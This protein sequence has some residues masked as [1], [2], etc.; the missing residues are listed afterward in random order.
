MQN[1]SAIPNQYRSAGV[2]IR[3]LTRGNGL[4]RPFRDLAMTEEAFATG[5]FRRPG[6]ICALWQ[7]E[8]KPLLTVSYFSCKNTGFIGFLTRSIQSVDCCVM[9]IFTSSGAALQIQAVRDHGDEFAVRRLALD[10]THSVAKE[11]LQRLQVAPVPGHPR[12]RARMARS[13]GKAWCRTSGPRRD[14]EPW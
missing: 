6:A 13:T 11:L 7:K 4:P 1:H 2:G 12:W 10:V 14:S 5:P 3:P 9:G 8:K